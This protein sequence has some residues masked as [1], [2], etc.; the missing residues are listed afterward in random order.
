MPP[1]TFGTRR[2]NCSLSMRN[3]GEGAER[4]TGG[5]SLER[6]P[7]QHESSESAILLVYEGL[8]YSSFSLFFLVVIKHTYYASAFPFQGLGLPI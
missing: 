6:P 1:S 3:K 8:V 7:T 4:Y 5:K 2:K